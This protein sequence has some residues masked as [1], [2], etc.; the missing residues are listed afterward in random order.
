MASLIKEALCSQRRL[1]MAEEREKQGGGQLSKALQMERDQ[2]CRGQISLPNP[3][4][5]AF[6]TAP[7]APTHSLPEPGC[8]LKLGDSKTLKR[9]WVAEAL[10]CS[11]SGLLQEPGPAELYSCQAEN[12]VWLLRGS[13]H[14][15][16]SNLPLQPSTSPGCL[17][18]LESHGG[19]CE[20]LSGPGEGYQR[21]F[22]PRGRW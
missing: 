18:G 17:K 1:G 20:Q 14:A 10:H 11:D 22:Q 4:G 7:S 15:S 6:L 5:R 2:F 3:P 8:Q 9:C 16:N 12:A 13:L 19:A 21:T